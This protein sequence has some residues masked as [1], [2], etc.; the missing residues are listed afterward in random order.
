MNRKKKKDETRQKSV[1][2]MAIN[3]Y[4]RHHRWRT[5]ATLNNIL[6]NYQ[7]FKREFLNVL[8]MQFLELPKEI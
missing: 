6:W 7:N 3:P 1:L 8:R 5:E 2:T 4:D